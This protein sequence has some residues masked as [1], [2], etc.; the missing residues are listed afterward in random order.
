MMRGNGQG[1]RSE[2]RKVAEQLAK[3]EGSSE[4][5]ATDVGVTAN[6]SE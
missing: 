4:D 5:T 1:G 3:R 6:E 2:A